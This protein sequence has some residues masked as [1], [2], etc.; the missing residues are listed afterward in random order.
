MDIFVGGLAAILVMACYVTSN[1]WVAAGGSA[2]VAGGLHVIGWLAQFY[3][4][5]VH[6]GRSPALVDN[7]FQVGRTSFP[8]PSI[9]WLE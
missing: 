5:G 9:S 4:H 1:L 7:L 3:G 8:F 2:A 6:E